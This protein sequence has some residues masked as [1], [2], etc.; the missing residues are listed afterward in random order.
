MSRK[1]VEAVK[2]FAILFLPLKSF[3]TIKKN[4]AKPEGL[5]LDWPCERASSHEW[6]KPT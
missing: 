3:I 5:D 2:I 6:G 4:I 1:A